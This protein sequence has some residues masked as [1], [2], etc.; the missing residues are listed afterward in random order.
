[1]TFQAPSRPIE[2]TI[3]D[4]IFLEPTDRQ[5]DAYYRVL[6]KGKV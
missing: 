6:T 5:L 1:M 3:L 4:E 2:R